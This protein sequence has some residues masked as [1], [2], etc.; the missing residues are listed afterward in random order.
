MKAINKFFYALLAFATVGMVACS[1][2][3]THEPGPAELEGCYGVYFPEASV[4]ETQGPMGETSLDPS[5]PTTFTY[6]A[7]RENTEGEITVPVEINSTLDA[8][9]LPMYTVEPIVFA[10][11]EDVAEFTVTLSD[12]AE[13]G[14]PYSLTVSVANDPQF[15]KQYDTA[16]ATMFSVTIN[17]VKWIDL[18]K[19]SFTEDVLTSFWNFGF[20]PAN[21]TYN[22]TV[23]VR[24]D[25][26]DEAAFEAAI[27]GTGDDSGLSGIYRIVNGWR[28]GVWGDDSDEEYNAAI[29]ADPI[30]TVFN[31]K[32]YNKVWVPLQELGLT[33]NGGMTSIYS[34]PAYYM[35]N[36]ADSGITDDMYGRIENGAIVFGDKQLLMCPGGDY[37][38]QNTYYSNLSG[39]F[40]LVLSPALGVYEL[41]MPDAEE[42]GDFSFTEVDLPAGALF[43]S[44]SQAAVYG[45]VL[46]K[47]RCEVSTKDADRIF[48]KEYGVLYR[49]PDLYVEGY[50]IFFSALEDG[51][52]TLP[53]AYINQATG[54]VQNGFDV[55]MAIDAEQ[56]KFDPATGLMTLVAEFHSG[57]GEDAVSY[58]TFQEVIAVE[59]PEFPVQPVADLKNDFSYSAF[60]TAP[61]TSE[62]MDSE[63]DVDVEKGTCINPYL[64]LDGTAYRMQSLYTNGYDI[65]FVADSEGN[66]GVTAGYELQ[67]TGVVIYGKAAYMQILGG[68]CNEKTV[69]LNAK[70]CDVEG[71]SLVPALCTE[72]VVNYTWVEVAT[73][74]YTNG[75]LGDA[76]GNPVPVPSR[77]LLNAEGTDMYKI[78]D[79]WGFEGYDLIFTWNKSTNKCE[80]VGACDCGYYYSAKGGNFC[81]ADCKTAYA[82]L[83]YDYDWPLLEKNGYMQ[84]TYNPQT[85]TFTFP[86][87]YVV[88]ES[89]SVFNPVTDTFVLDGAPQENT[90]ENVAVGT[91]THT[92]DFFVYPENVPYAEPNLVL[93]RYGQTNKY[94]IVGL[95]AGV[96]DL[97]MTFDEA[98]GVV[99]IP[100]TKT[101][102]QYEEQDGSFTDIWAGDAWAMMRDWGAAAEGITKEQVYAAYPNSYDAATKTFSFYLGYY[103]VYGYTY[104]DVDEG[105]PTV[106]TFQITGDAPA[107]TSSLAP[108][109]TDA[110]KVKKFNRTKKHNVAPRKLSTLK[111]TEAN[112]SE[113]KGAPA[114]RSLKTV[115]P[116]KRQTMF[117]AR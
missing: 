73:G 67:P 12:K 76:D 13:V 72:T 74:T 19:C 88:F 6:Y 78:L 42:D 66:V 109:S 91:F 55:L 96:F 101:G 53:K 79:Y 44:E 8:D 98:A 95:G 86:V 107:A 36:G 26:I 29:A 11:G 59:A 83:G 9:Q 84:P 117:L 99:E 5:E 40:K 39:N 25:S 106:H 38:G 47:G 94:K 70:F 50:P 75:L 77:P 82:L 22:V 100:G 71:N 30:Y 60:Y 41:N 14:V 112:L 68:T 64:E 34:L 46:E 16:N 43:Y 110:V 52:V 15:V 111:T 51:T 114:A 105:N 89:G 54:L 90:W 17:R 31:C 20:D 104:T 37:V 80:I 62:F 45:P 10:D 81:A 97:D 21:P 61:M 92:T 1:E 49:L 113:I 3:T 85:L 93:Q 7:Y 4:L 23:Q 18:G 58:G 69:V 65:Y 63:F 24:A 27:A 103:D 33:I 115:T 116:V 56:S 102:L 32:P 2:D 48:Y 108:A 35:D 57:S 87:M 28:V